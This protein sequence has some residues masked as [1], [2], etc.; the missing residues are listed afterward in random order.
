MMIIGLENTHFIVILLG[1]ELRGSRKLLVSELCYT[2]KWKGLHLFTGG[3]KNVL[4]GFGLQ[5]LYPVASG[6]KAMSRL[7]VEETG[8]SFFNTVL[9]CN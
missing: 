1:L 8:H 5:G 4:L 6:F 2:E 3:E 9:S 7:Q